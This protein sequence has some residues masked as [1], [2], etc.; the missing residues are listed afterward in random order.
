VVLHTTETEGLPGYDGGGSAPHLTYNPRDR[1]W[2]QHTDLSVAARALRNL[3]G[4]VETNRSRSLQVEIICYSDKGVADDDPS[5]R[6]WV[7]DLDSLALSDLAAFIEWCGAEYGVEAVWPG[8]A[9]LSYSQANAEG[10]RFTAYEWERFGGV[11]GHQHVTENDHWDPGALDWP[12]MMGGVGNVT[13]PNGEPNWDEV[14][15]W[16]R[17]A[18]TE[19]HEAGLLT[20]D[21]HPRDSLEVE[22]LMV[23]LERAGVI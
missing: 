1:T 17:A 11:C 2:T 12:T 9:A 4:G 23:Y 5:D 8:R 6:T 7:G 3:S 10:F 22:Q 19:A 21:S 15:E 16:A 20:D 18:W 14:S 13:G